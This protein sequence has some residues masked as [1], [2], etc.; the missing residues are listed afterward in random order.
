MYKKKALSF[1]DRLSSS[2][3]RISRLSCLE[4]TQFIALYVAT[5][6]FNLLLH[7][8]IL[9]A[10]KIIER[11]LKTY[12]SWSKT[13]RE[14]HQGLQKSIDEKKIF[15][16]LLHWPLVSSPARLWLA[17]KMRE[18][19]GK[20]V[21]SLFS[22]AVFLISS[23]PIHVKWKFLIKMHIYWQASFLTFETEK[24]PKTQVIEPF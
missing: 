20:R 6:A 16:F 3:P 9:W 22:A 23:I 2:L 8:V 19:A 18:A 13:Q 21:I 17:R 10:L 15:R 7:S 12:L 11:K 4:Y 24:I 5:P 1:A 14:F